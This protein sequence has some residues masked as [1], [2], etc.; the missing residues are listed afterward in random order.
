MLRKIKLDTF[1]A[2]L[3]AV[4]LGAARFG[5][6]YDDER[7][8]ELLDYYYYELGGRF[9]D[10]ANVYGRW[11]KDG[12]NH[13][14]ITIGKWLAERKITDMVITSKCVHYAPG[15]NNISRVN[16]EEAMKDIE[17]SRR[18]LGMDEIPIYLTHR[19]NPEVDVRV[20]VDFMAEMVKNGWIK[21]FGF[22]NYTADRVKTA[23]EYMGDDWREMFVGASNEWSL[24]L[25]ATAA[26]KGGKQP[27]G[28]GIVT[29]D[30]ELW[31]MHREM[32]VPLIPF[33]SAAHGFYAKAEARG[34]ENL[35]Q[36]EQKIYSALK[37]ESAKNGISVNS[38]SVA[39]LLNS[40]VPA[41]PIVAVSKIEQLKEFE[42]IAGF[43][44]N[45]GYLSPFANM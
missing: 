12:L 8:F 17:S 20:I 41:I 9:L 1:P 22:S 4:C 25:E 39:Y 30:I 21:R 10:T 36:N 45:L 23:I 26:E 13:S 14:E 18:A 16:S 32:N 6:D 5:G 37:Q 43:E 27:S 15:H 2:P 34:I 44:G 24:H 19:D 29:T 33:S 3:S 40:G 35:P 28:D 42:E 7:S 31:R 38:T 11:S